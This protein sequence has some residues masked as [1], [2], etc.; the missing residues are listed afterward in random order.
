[1]SQI[2]A[3]NG[4][5]NQ[6]QRPDPAAMKAKID[7][8]LKAGGATDDEIANISGPDGVKELAS[9]YGVSLPTPPQRGQESI[10]NAQGNQ[11]GESMK[12]KVDNQ[13]T[14]A[15]ATTAEISAAAAQG[16]EGIKALAEKYG[17]ELPQPPQRPNKAGNGEDMKAKIDSLLKAGGATDDEIANISGPDDVQEL[18]DKYGVTLPT[19]PQNSGT[20]GTSSSNG[21]SQILTLLSSLLGSNSLSS[22]LSDST[23][24]STSTDSSLSSALLLNVFSSLASGGSIIA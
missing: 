7:S 23:S 19:P 17:V 15:G 16:P 2:T 10:F 24:T 14:A 1:M 21:L 12:A 22:L 9:K 11:N 5:Y 8:L 20:N 18:A 13:L 3:I 4:N 6:V